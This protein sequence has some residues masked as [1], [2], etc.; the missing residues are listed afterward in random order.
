M[1]KLRNPHDKLFKVL[2]GEKEA[3]LDLLKMGLPKELFEQ[4]D[5][6]SI[7]S[8]KD[9]FIDEELSEHFSDLIFSCKM[10]SG[11]ECVISF[12]LEHKSYVPDFPHVQLLQYKINGYKKQ[13]GDPNRR[14]LSPI[15]PII[16]YHGKEPWVEKAFTDYFNFVDPILEKYI[17]GFEY[18]LLN[19]SNWTDQAIKQL[20]TGF[21]KAA[22]LLMKHNRNKTYLLHHSSEIFKFAN[23]EVRKTGSI[24]LFFLYVTTVYELNTKELKYMIDQTPSN[25]KKTAK[26]AYDY[27]IEEGVEKGNLLTAIKTVLRLFLQF[28]DMNISQ[29]ATVTGLEEKIIKLLKNEVYQQ[30]ESKAGKILE[31]LFLDVGGLKPKEL[32][33]ILV[34]ALTDPL[35]TRKTID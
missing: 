31:E 35:D 33:E 23:W 24:K 5:G 32:K 6:S 20:R 8:E 7:N 12:L 27:I 30:D 22:L 3:A 11:K 34:L 10:K 9:S 1:K 16:L 28:P 29:I 19:L 18:C 26:V 25:M 4:L 21:A 15:I 17:P 14:L 13:V 2:F